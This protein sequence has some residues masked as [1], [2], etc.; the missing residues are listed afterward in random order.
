MDNPI[1]SS[2]NK[3]SYTPEFKLKLAL[4]AIKK[5]SLS[6]V[7]RKYGVAVNVLSGWR[8]LVLEQGQNIFKSTPSKE[9]KHL[10]VKTAQLEQ[11][12]GKKEVEPA[13][14]K[15]FSDFYSSQRKP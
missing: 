8:A 4:E 15:N 14:L 2:K 12:L 5:D 13:L 7:S 11:M 9:R 6:E 1:K 10:E 3:K